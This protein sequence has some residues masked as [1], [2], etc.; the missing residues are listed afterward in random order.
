MKTFKGLKAHAGQHER[1]ALPAIFATPTTVLR[2]FG[3]VP[4]DLSAL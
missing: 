2:K 4:D 3:E 1:S